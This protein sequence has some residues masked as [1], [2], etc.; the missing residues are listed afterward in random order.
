MTF[1]NYS[2]YCLVIYRP[3]WYSGML[4]APDTHELQLLLGI[5]LLASW[6][7]MVYYGSSLLALLLTR[8]H[9][10]SIFAYAIVSFLLL[11][12]S[13]LLKFQHGSF[14]FWPSDTTLQTGKARMFSVVRNV[15]YNGYLP[16]P[17]WEKC[18]TTPHLHS[19]A[20]TEWK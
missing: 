12:T 14:Y 5:K 13:F 8:L 3:H 6:F 2:F 15:P 1:L 16:I 9:L 10:W 19:M 20:S 11:L 4:S 18:R 7:S 17:F